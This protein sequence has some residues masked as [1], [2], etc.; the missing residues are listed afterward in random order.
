MGR[1]EAQNYIRLRFP[2]HRYDHVQCLSR[3]AFRD[4]GIRYAHRVRI[5]IIDG[6]HTLDISDCRIHRIGK[7]YKKY[8][9]WFGNT[10]VNYRHIHRYICTSGR[11]GLYQ[12]GDRSVI[13]H[14]NGRIIGSIDCHTHLTMNRLR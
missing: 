5:V 3:V 12:R 14:C 9:L 2:A 7:V 6:T 4:G 8:F 1:G 11:D 10:I 13:A